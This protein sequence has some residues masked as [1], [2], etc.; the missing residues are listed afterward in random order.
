[1]CV[2][3]SIKLELDFLSPLGFCKIVPFL[4]LFPFRCG[5][6][7]F[8]LPSGSWNAAAL[9]LTCCL[10]CFCAEAIISRCLA[11]PLELSGPV[12]QY[13]YIHFADTVRGKHHPPQAAVILEK[14]KVSVWQW[15]K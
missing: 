1:M 4:S 2:L 7:A 8:H 13:A 10:V 9:T 5:S 6:F 12:V 3:G 11:T 15:W 14:E